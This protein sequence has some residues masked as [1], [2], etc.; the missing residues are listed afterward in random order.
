MNEL[1]INDSRS[2]NK[3]TSTKIFA[4]MLLHESLQRRHDQLDHLIGHLL[5]PVSV[6]LQHARQLM[7]F[8]HL[9]QQVEEACKFV[10]DST[11]PLVFLLL[12]SLHQRRE[13]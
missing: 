13:V 4:S 2:M 3:L 1:L 7:P 12:Q 6:I 8:G 5:P 10:L 9:L 11:L